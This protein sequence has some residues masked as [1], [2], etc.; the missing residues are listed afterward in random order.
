MGLEAAGP[1]CSLAAIHTR[2]PH[3]HLNKP[4]LLGVSDKDCRNQEFFVRCARPIRF[5]KVRAH[6]DRLH[7]PGG[8]RDTEVADEADLASFPPDHEPLR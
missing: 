4:G 7:P 1:E 5:Y 3:R 6:R 2:I 8:H